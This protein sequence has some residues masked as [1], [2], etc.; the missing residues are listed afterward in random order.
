MFYA[1]CCFLLYRRVFLGSKRS[2]TKVRMGNQKY[3]LGCD[4]A[5]AVSRGWQSSFYREN[6]PVQINRSRFVASILSA[7]SAIRSRSS[8]LFFANVS[9]LVSSSRRRLSRRSSCCCNCVSVVKSRRF[10][11]S[12]SNKIGLGAN[13]KADFHSGGMLRPPPTKCAVHPAIRDLVGASSILAHFH[14]AA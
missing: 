1:W 11:T 10:V 6:P 5:S 9:V 7:T 2:P 12:R 4:T 13:A 3:R 8:V 14:V